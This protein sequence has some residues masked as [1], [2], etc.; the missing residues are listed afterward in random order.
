MQQSIPLNNHFVKF[1]PYN[2][3]TL[4]ALTNKTIKFS[5][6]YD[7]NDFNEL[8][9]IAGAHT[10][11]LTEEF[12]K[13]IEEKLNDHDFRINLFQKAYDSGKYERL[14]LKGFKERLD[15]YPK[16]GLKIFKQKDTR[17]QNAYYSLIQE[18]MAFLS[19]GIFCLSN[20]KVFC[21]DSAQLMFAHYGQNLKGLAL[22]YEATPETKYFHRVEYGEEELNECPACG[23]PL[24]SSQ[25]N[26]SSSQRKPAS[27]GEVGRLFTKWLREDYTDIGDFTK[28]SSKWFYEQEHR[29]F[30]EPSIHNAEERGFKL[31]GILYTPRFSQNDI[32]TLN[33]LNIKIYQKTLKIIEELYP[34]PCYYRF[35]IDGMSAYDYLIEKLR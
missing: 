34:S 17:Y 27:V 18:N 31:K 11:D 15:L 20:L 16:E 35:D 2:E 33:H 12:K 7:F 22:I 3:R 24:L 19:V 23:K 25:L 6:V 4:S 1:V 8:Q 26:K 13:Q 32:E 14:I 9:F 30:A 28:K 5:T 29:A 21:D 10:A